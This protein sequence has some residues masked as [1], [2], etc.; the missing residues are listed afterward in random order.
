MS[1]THASSSV[2]TGGGVRGKSVRRRPAA[3]RPEYVN[4]PRSLFERIRNVTLAADVMFVNGLPFFV[5]LSRD[6]KLITL[7]FLPSRTVPMLCDTLKKTLV[8]YRRGGFVVRTCLM[9]MEFEKLVN[10]M[11]EVVIN[12]TAAREH[13]GDVER[14]IRTIKGQARSV[15]SELPYKSCMPN[16]IIIHL[17]KFVTMWINALPSGSGVSTVLSPREIV[18]HHKMDFTKHCRVRFGAYVEAHDDPDV[19]NTL[20][21]RTTACIALG[22][23]GNLQGSI[24]CFDL[25]TG[26]VI[27]RRTVT[28]LPMPDRII[29]AV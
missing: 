4:I 15:S 3:V 18:T 2:Q 24:A 12:T 7:E 25:T 27:K 6:I 16:L 28:P 22:P 10:E 1:L 5:T 17:L 19:S 11:D 13:V 14:C 9:D 20:R 8:I 26:R 23:T 29:K 21:D